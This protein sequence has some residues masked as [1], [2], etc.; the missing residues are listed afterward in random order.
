MKNIFR[1]P[2]VFL[3]CFRGEF[4]VRV[5][6]TGGGGSLPDALDDPDF[7]VAGVSLARTDRRSHTG[8]RNPRPAGAQRASHRDTR[9]LDA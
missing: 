7:A 1:F 8:R 5:I 2:N 3:S 4:G 6:L 9:G